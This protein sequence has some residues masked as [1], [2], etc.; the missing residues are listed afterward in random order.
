ME[1]IPVRYHVLHETFYDYGSPVSL[2]QQQ[3]HLSPRVLA[4]QQIEEQRIDIKPTPTWRRALPAATMEP[5]N[6][7]CVG[8]TDC[9]SALRAAFSRATPKPK[10]H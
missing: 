9:C 2:S 1:K 5:S 7:S 10:T 4:W 8:T 6:A 3:L